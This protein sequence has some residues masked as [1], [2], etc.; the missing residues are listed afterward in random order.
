MPYLVVVVCI[1]L[2]AYAAGGVPI[3]TTG[4]GEARVCV[5]NSG[6]V[7]ER[8]ARRGFEVEIVNGKEGD[9]GVGGKE[10]NVGVV[11]EKSSFVG[12]KV[13][14]KVGERGVRGGETS[15]CMNW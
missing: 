12:D 9:V 11:G 14:E 4:S 8:V 6:S 13:E 1:L 7:W 5:C 15:K 3:C 10:A 2:G